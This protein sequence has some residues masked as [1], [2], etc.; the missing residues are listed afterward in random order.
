[1]RT[2]IR[3]AALAALAVALAG[4]LAACDDTT[5]STQTG[6]RGTGMVQLSTTETKAALAAANVVP[7]PQ[8]PASNDGPRARELYQNV[9]VLGD[10]SD[11]EF[12]RT[13]AAITEWIAPDT[14][15]EYCHNVENLAEDSK[16]TKIVARKMLEMTRHINTAWE[17][18][19]GQTGVTCYTCHRGNA[20]PANV[21]T[22]NPGAPEARGM[23][24]TETGQNHPA[25]VAGLA[26]LPYDP[27][28]TLYGDP[29][30][31]RVQS[32][33]ALPPG[34]GKSIQQTEKTYSLM[35]HMSEGLG[36][37]CTFCHNSR[38]FA[39][40]PDSNPQRVTAW[41]GIRMVSDVNAT[42]I[43][44]L[45]SVFPDNRK[46]PLGDPAKANCTTCHQGANKPLLGVSMLKD[47][48]ASLKPTAVADTAPAAAAPAAT[49]APTN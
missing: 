31:I 49:P 24:R 21:W 44:P 27:F 13:M 22:K 30:G 29:T 23:A 19:V 3:R 38:D 11:E 46:G 33:V 5:E 26:S 9:Q 4:G 43:D 28:T 34:S 37:N 8:P 35:V 14:G 25:T 32:K 6:Y 47:Y 41:H 15:C 39:N 2:L 40:W 16:Y 18:H 17:A 12:N 42:Y 1:M 10:L 36:V 45:A 48:L 7:E 20:V